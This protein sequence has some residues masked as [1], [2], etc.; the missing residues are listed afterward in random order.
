MSE[1]ITTIDFTRRIRD[2]IKKHNFPM[3]IRRRIEI[4]EPCL[5]MFEEYSLGL[6]IYGEGYR[7][8]DDFLIRNI[9]I[10]ILWGKKKKI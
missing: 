8:A 7:T 1:G 4:I 2:E 6:G 10:L 9:D 3:D 5:K